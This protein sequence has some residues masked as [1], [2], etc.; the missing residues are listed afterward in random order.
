MEP[1][2]EDVLRLVFQSYSLDILKLVRTEPRRFK[3]LQAQ[4][5]TRQTLSLRLAKLIEFRLI[6]VVPLKV[7]ERY[8]NYYRITKK[9]EKILS[10]ITKI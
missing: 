7:K 1:S 6:E 8:A 3:D 5:P 4:L 9:G 10:V 2:S